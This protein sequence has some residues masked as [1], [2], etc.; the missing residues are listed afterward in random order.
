MHLAGTFVSL[1]RQQNRLRYWLT[2]RGGRQQL[3]A[4]PLATMDCGVCQQLS[5]LTYVTCKVRGSAALL[6]V[7]RVQRLTLSCDLPFGITHC[8]VS[9]QCSTWRMLGRAILTPQSMF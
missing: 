8:L 9:K 5:Y 3:T 6:Q 7:R 4:A 1:M 2:K